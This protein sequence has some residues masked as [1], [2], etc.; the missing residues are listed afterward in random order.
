M[1]GTPL[2][3][4]FMNKI[5]KDLYDISVGTYMIKNKSQLFN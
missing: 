4:V 5:C 2:C 3:F 1:F